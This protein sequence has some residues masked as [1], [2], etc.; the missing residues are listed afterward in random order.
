MKIEKL[1]IIPMSLFKPFKLSI[2]FEDWKDV[3][4]FKSLLFC[5]KPAFKGNPYFHRVLMLADSLKHI[6]KEER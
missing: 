6:M 5:V 3:N 4:I 1:P 2:T